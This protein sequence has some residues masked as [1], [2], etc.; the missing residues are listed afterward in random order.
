MSLR[1]GS[2]FGARV[3]Q[4]VGGAVGGSQRILRVMIPSDGHILLMSCIQLNL[5]VLSHRWLG[6][7]P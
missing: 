3:S 4:G 6:E 2:F 1:R 5:I 7:S